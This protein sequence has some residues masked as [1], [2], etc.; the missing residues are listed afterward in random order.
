[1]ARVV[2]KDL[3]KRYQGGTLAVDKLNLDIADGEFICLVGPSGCGKTTALRMIAGL[4]DISGGEVRIGDR[5]VNH[6]SPRDRDIAM[7]FQSYALY[8]HMSVYDNMAFGLQ[9]RKAPKQDIDKA[10]HEAARILDLERFLKRKPGQL[11]GGQRQRVALGRA[12]V[13]E[14]A[15]FLMDEPLSNLDAKLRVQTRAEIARLHHRLTAT[16]IYVTHDQV[17]AMTM[18]DRIAVMS[19]GVLQQ[20][21]TPR[22]LYESPQN[23]FVAGFIGSPSMNFITHQ[24]SLDGGSPRLASEGSEVLLDPKQTDLLRQRQLKTVEVGVRPEHLEIGER[25]GSGLRAAAKV[26]V[27]EFLGND[28]LIHAMASGSDM[29]ALVRVDD[30]LSVGSNVILTAPANRIHL[31]DPETGEALAVA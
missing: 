30:S 6:L 17:E 2:L 5:V 12:I 21:G 11:S 22:E 7:V 20:V 13:R 23:R 24:V 28:Q 27:I 15:A 18:G 29:V 3:T 14:P 8:P 16:M 31:F 19:E 25:N 10:V 4:E 26:D 1:M 9:L